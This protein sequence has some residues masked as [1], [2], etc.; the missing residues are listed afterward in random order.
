MKSVIILMLLFLA[1]QVQAAEF[2]IGKGVFHGGNY[3]PSDTASGGVELVKLDASTYELRLGSNFSTTPGPD[4]FVYLSA[5]EDHQDA[6][7]ITD[8]TYFEAGKLGSPSG[9]Q[10]LVLPKNFDPKKFRSVAIWCKQYS[11]LFGAAALYNHE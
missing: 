10:K 9:E 7:A 4:L 2:I 1:T 3:A 5:S 6:A 8:N 11:V